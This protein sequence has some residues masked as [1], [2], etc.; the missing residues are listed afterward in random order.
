VPQGINVEQIADQ[1]K[2]V[3]RA[4]GEFVHSFIEALGI[5]L[6][7]S[8]VALGLGVPGSWSRCR[9][10]WCWRSSSSSWKR[11]VDRTCNRI[12][13]GAPDHRARPCLVDD[14]IIAV[15]DDGGEDGGRA[16][17]ASARRP[18]P[19]INCVSDAHGNAGHGPLA[20][21]P[22]A[23]PI[24]RSAKYA[25]RHL[26]DRGDRRGR[27]LVRRRDLHAPIS[28]SSCCRNITVHHNHDPAPR[29]M[30][31]RVYRILRSMVQ[32]CVDHRVKVVLATIGVFALLDRRLRSRAAAVFFPLSERPELFLQLRLPEGTSRSNVTEKSVK[33]AEALLKDD[34]DIATF[35]SLCSRPGF[36][37]ASGLGLNPQLPNEGLCRDRDRLQGCRSPRAHQGSAGEGPVAD[38]DLSEARVRCRPLQLWSPR[39][40]PGSVSA[41][42]GPDANK[43]AR[44]S[45]TRLRDVMAA[46][47]PTAREPQLDWNEQS[48]LSE[49]GGRSGSRPAPLGLTPQGRPRRPL[50]MLISGAPGHHYSRRHREGRA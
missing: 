14:A 35:T 34:K 42:I 48:A 40:F 46:K 2:V 37:R 6:F 32:W 29:S 47:T 26:L 19:G 21:S 11:D 43:V 10:R 12:T 28:A 31:P 36:R 24:P 3:E 22:S 44:Q 16:G 38:G 4:V 17:T 25:G 9:C 18:L 23:L 13:L 39:R 7:V 27:F 33:K 1:P 30:R 8:F 20:S 45:P 50:A 5:V 41:V 49:A 15:D